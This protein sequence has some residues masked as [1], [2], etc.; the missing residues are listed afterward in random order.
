[1]DASYWTSLAPIRTV[2]IA[3][4]ELNNLRGRGNGKT[5]KDIIDQLSYGLEI[6]FFGASLKGPVHLQ[7]S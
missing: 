2:F 7:R 3:G 6:V 1:M 5:A 4:R